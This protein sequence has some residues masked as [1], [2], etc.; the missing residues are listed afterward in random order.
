MEAQA[1]PAADETTPWYR[2]DVPV[3]TLPATIITPGS[4]RFSPRP[5]LQGTRLITEDLAPSAWDELYGRSARQ[6][7][8][9]VL[10]SGYAMP[11]SGD[12]KG[13]AVL[14]VQGGGHTQT[15]GLIGGVNQ[16]Q[17][18]GNGVLTSRALADPNTDTLNLQGQSL[19]PT[20]ASLVRKAGTLICRPAAAGSAASVA[21]AKARGKPQKAVR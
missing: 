16:I 2:A 4:Q 1:G 13:P 10:S 21:T 12:F 7:Q 18:N 17:A 6:A 20:T 11:G 19:G 8:T 3:M 14:T 5:D 15:I 9:D